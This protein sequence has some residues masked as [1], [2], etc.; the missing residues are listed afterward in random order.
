MLFRGMFRLKVLILVL[1]SFFLEGIGLS[2]DYVLDKMG[3]KFLSKNY[4]RMVSLAPSLT[5]ILVFLDLNNRIVG[6][7]RYCNLLTQK[8]GGI[9]DPDIERIVLLKPDLV[10]MLKLGSRENYDEL[11][12]R[13]IPVFVFDF[14]K[15]EDLITGMY[16]ISRLMNLEKNIYEKIN[17]F[18][19]Q[20][21]SLLKD[22]RRHLKGK[23]I[24]V[25]YSYP[26]IYTASS[27]SFVADVIRKCGGVNVADSFPYQ[28]QTIIINFERLIMLKPDVV[29]ISDPNF[30]LITNELSTY[31]L[32][33]KFVFVEPMDLSP[34]LRITNFIHN[35]VNSVSGM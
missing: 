2:K 19:N 11:V 21:E 15:L 13:N 10:L 12:K 20:L 30:H 32:K 1:I 6:T 9:Y 3:T 29:I 25:M 4:S 24:F 31:G 23:R 17:S 14:I 5:E 34:S 28:Y 16:E 35:L 7:T 18:S 27:N 33:S 22:A 8:V 26:D